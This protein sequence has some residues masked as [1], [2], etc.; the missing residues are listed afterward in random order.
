MANALYGLGKQKFLEGTIDFITDTINCVLVDLAD[1]TLA[2]NTDD[3]LDDIPVAARVATA[4]LSGKDVTLGVFDAN[5]VTFSSV[6]G[7]QSE[8]LVIYKNTGVDATSPL[9]AFVDIATGLPITPGGGDI[10]VT[11][12]SGVNKIFAL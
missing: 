7:D 3:F 6:T 8:A 1:Y 9:I 5:D 10:V 4:T 2:I 11:W 12:D